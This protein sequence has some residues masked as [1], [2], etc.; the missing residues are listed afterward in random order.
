MKFN[1]RFNLRKSDSKK[2]EKIYLVCRFDGLKFVYPTPFSVV[3]KNWNKEKEGIRNVIEELERDMINKHLTELKQAARLI[4][5]DAVINK[6]PVTKIILKTELDKWTGKTI[7]NKPVF[8][9]WLRNWIDTSI[10][11][12]NPKTGRKISFR[13]IQEY[14]T[15]YKYLIELEKENKE[16]LQFE[17]INLNTLKDFR[18]FL[19]TVKGFAV[20]NI[21]KHIDNLRQFLRAAQLEDIAIDP[22]AVNPSHFIIKRENADNIYLNES[23]LKQIEKLN[24]SG[25]TTLDKVRDLFLIG[26]FTGLRISDFSNIKPYNIKGEF[27]EIVQFKTGDKVTIPLH[28]VVKGIFKKYDNKAIPKISEQKFNKYIKDIAKDAGL[29][30]QTE[31]QQTKGGLKVVQV[32]EKW[33]LVS[34]HTARRSFATNAVKKGVPVQVVMKITGHK[35]ESV[36]LKY[37]KLNHFEYAE[38]MQKHL[39]KSTN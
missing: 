28:E 9:P 26:C 3:P 19:T 31:K 35:K 20:N 37:I 12:I 34:S 2:P 6:I 15:T 11:R 32:L 13:T 33:Q 23:E 7:E 27:I 5:T 10:D 25:N 8:K 39:N 4:Y 16:L 18:D 29:K 1:T 36:F 38:I 21:A 17:N 22:H 14:N 30:E 24:L